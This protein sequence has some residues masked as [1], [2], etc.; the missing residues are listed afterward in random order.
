MKFLMLTGN[1]LLVF[2]EQQIVEILAGW[3]GVSCRYKPGMPLAVLSSML[4]S[5]LLKGNVCC[6]TMGIFVVNL[7]FK[8]RPVCIFLADSIFMVGE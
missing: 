1:S 4:W 5:C 2:M 3:S 7:L 8:V 6:F